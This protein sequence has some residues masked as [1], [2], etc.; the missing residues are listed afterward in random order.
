MTPAI[1]IAFGIC[2]LYTFI[3][4]SIV[5]H[6]IVLQ[7]VNIDFI[8]TIDLSQLI[9]RIQLIVWHMKSYNSIALHLLRSS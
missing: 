6:I 3:I 9:S 7:F 4:Q 5:H 8:L 1:T 2:G